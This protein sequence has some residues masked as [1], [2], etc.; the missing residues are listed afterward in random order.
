M[1]IAAGKIGI[2]ITAPTNTLSID[3]TAARTFWM[4]RHTTANTAGNNLTMQSGGATSGATDKNGGDLILASAIATGNGESKI[5]FQ[6]V[7]TSQGA[8]TTD[9]A[10]ATRLQIDDGG[11]LESLGTAPTLSACGTTPAISGTDTAG[12]VTIGTG[13]TTSCTVT[14]AKAYTNAPA[15]AISGDNTAVTYIATTTTTVL[16][17]TSSADMASDVISYICLGYE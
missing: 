7:D 9:R 8:G 11:H 5:I 6:T 12:K 2:G 13:V 15:C 10:A 3:G 4:E 1:I 17:I 14:F 16:T